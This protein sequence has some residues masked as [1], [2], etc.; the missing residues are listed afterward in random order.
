MLTLL[1]NISLL[2]LIILSLDY[3]YLGGILKD[4]F[5]KVIKKIQKKEG[6]I[7]YGYSAVVYILIITSIHYFIIKD[8]KSSW[9]AFVLGIIIYG[10]FDFTNLAIFS[11]YSLPLAIHD[12]LWG[13]TLFFLTTKIFDL[14]I[15][16]KKLF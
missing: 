16:K 12:T 14:I 6:K 4:P 3:L 8:K 2:A 13:G 10:V 11:D 7:N 1:R 9:D 15:H 5:M